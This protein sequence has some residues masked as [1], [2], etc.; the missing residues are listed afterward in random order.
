MFNVSDNRGTHFAIS[1]SAD[2]SRNNLYGTDLLAY[3]FPIGVGNLY[4]IYFPV[5]ETLSTTAPNTGIIRIRPFDTSGT[6][7]QNRNTSNCTSPYCYNPY[8]S[9]GQ[10]KPNGMLCE[11]NPTSTVV[12]P[13]IYLVKITLA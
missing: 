1:G 4:Y 9:T 2:T 8:T 7:C 5:N 10:I 12:N 3:F 6:N 13:E 11:N